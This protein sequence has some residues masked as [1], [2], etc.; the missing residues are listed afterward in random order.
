MLK[1]TLQDQLFSCDFAESLE[2]NR[3]KAKEITPFLFL[4]LSV[5]KQTN[6]QTNK[7]THKQRAEQNILFKVGFQ[8][9]EKSI[10]L[11]FPQAGCVLG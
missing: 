6:K 11:Y 3:V 4:L 5:L 8:C 10:G 2:C 9:Y 1:Y 7:Q